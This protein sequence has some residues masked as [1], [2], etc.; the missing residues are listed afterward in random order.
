MQLARESGAD[1]RLDTAY[2]M[3]S[4]DTLEDNKA[5]ALKE[6]TDFRC[7]ESGQE[8]ASPRVISPDTPPERAFAKRWTCIDPAGTIAFI[9][10]AVA[11]DVRTGHRRQARRTNAKKR[12]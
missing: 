8:N 5:F 1:S 11:G 6:H 3:I 2:F 9:D 12:K 10:K 4:V 7:L